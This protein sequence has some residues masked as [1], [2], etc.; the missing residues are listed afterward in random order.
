MTRHSLH[1]R[2]SATAAGPSWPLEI[3]CP[4]FAATAHVLLVVPCLCPRPFVVRDAAL[5]FV[6]V[7][8]EL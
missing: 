4:S 1:R 8:L 7:C 6:I 5:L 2:G 3:R